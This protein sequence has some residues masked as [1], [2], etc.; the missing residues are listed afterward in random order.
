MRNS[1]TKGLFFVLGWT[2]A[3][4][5]AG[6]RPVPVSAQPSETVVRGFHVGL[7]LHAG[8]LG[9]TMLKSVDNTAPNTLVPDPRR[10]RV[11]HDEA[12]GDGAAHG[13]GL[14]GGYRL[15]L[16]GGAWFLDGE[17]GFVWH[18]G[19]T[20]AQFA[21]VGVSPERRQLGE[22]WPDTWELSKEMSYGATLRLGGSPGGLGSRGMAAYLLAGVRFAG[23]GFINHYLGCFSPDP[24]E[25]SEFRS[26]REEM[27]MDFTVWRGGIGLEKSLGTRFAIRAE[28]DYS[29]YATEAWVTRF[30][31]VVVT[32]DS[33]MEASEVGLSLGLIRRF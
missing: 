3:G 6:G 24:C 4:P 19:A 25:P 11:F 16:S 21:G 31:D 27:D 22:S 20:E 15:P 13:A 5:M 7:A 12:S 33:S 8:Q 10:G 29:V 26:G 2:L 14:V 17:V 32:V 9:A 30:N 1:L 28:A 18:G 23:V